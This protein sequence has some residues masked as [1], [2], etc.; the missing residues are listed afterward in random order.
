MIPA[1]LK[2]AAVV[3]DTKF[4]LSVEVFVAYFERDMST[5]GEVIINQWRV[6]IFIIR[7]NKDK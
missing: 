6:L 5:P 3:C 4:G 2:I 1:L 7:S